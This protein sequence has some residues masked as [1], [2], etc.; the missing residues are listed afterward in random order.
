MYVQD[1]DCFH[2]ELLTTS[3]GAPPSGKEDKY[4]GGAGRGSWSRVSGSPS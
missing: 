2:Y 1:F 4:P 3:T